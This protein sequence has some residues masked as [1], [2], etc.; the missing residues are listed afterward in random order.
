MKHRSTIIN[1]GII[2]QPLG[3]V[4]AF[5]GIRG[6]MP[7]I[8]GSQGCSTY[9]RFQLTRHFRE[10]VNIASSS[11]SEAT[12]V[13]GGEENL[14]RALKT[15]EEQY[16]PEVIGVISGCLSE[17][18]GDDIDRIVDKHRE[19]GGS[20]IITVSSPGFRGSHVD[21]YEAAV[22]SIL[23]SLVMEH[24][25]PVDRINIINGIMSP[26]DTSE[27]K[28]ILE[29]M[30]VDFLMITDNS[31]SLDE[32]FDG[33]PY[34]ITR[35]G[36]SIHDIATAGDSMATL[37]LGGYG[38]GEFL[39]KKYGVKNIELPIPAGL[40]GTDKF[41]G[42]LLDLFHSD[43]SR[44]IRRERGRLMDAMIDSHQYTS[45][46]R[47][48]I[49]ADPSYVVAVTSLV[50]EMGMQPYVFTGSRSRYFHEKISQFQRKWGFQFPAESGVD[51]SG[52][53]ENLA[54][55]E[56]DVLIGNSHCARV[57]RELGVP[58]LRMGF[59]V[60]D[61]VGSQRIRIAGYGGGISFVDSL[62]NLILESHYDDGYEIDGDTCDKDS[63]C[64]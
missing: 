17:T 22:K 35:H 23:R 59:P 3:A 33:D 54:G 20:E 28:N 29:G 40:E 27:I 24:A 6:S 44:S 62:T 60:Y 4:M 63:C 21:G 57:A 50:L 42:V 41:L 32:P 39:E 58:L 55:R 38:G 48:A 43:I 51:I 15:V 7:L 52:L 2:C 9:M 1:P 56:V 16:S 10:P 46:R 64:I 49:F 5:L 53:K 25:E 34:F 61:R 36:T 26:A 19:S 18:I 30:G 13:Y 11:L 14:L 45:G 47:V 31:E 8:H 12:V 37:N